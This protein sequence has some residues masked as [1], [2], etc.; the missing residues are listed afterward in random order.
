MPSNCELN[1]E[2]FSINVREISPILSSILGS[3]EYT[4]FVRSKDSELSILKYADFGHGPSQYIL[5]TSQYSIPTREASDAPSWRLCF[6]PFA[7][8]E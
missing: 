1:P 3:F 5:L 4:R 2:V 7:G 8:E 6:S